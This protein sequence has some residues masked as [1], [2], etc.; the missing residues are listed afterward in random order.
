MKDL[1]LII[2]PRVPNHLL[3]KERKRFVLPTLFLG[4]AALLLVI[5][6]LLPYWKMTLYAPQ[7]PSG[8]KLVVY[9]NRVTGDVNE[10]D[11]LNHYIG[12]RS[13]T[14]AASLERTLSIIAVAVI[15]L[16]VIGAIYVH[17]PMALF[18]AIPA[19]AFPLLF[20]GDLWFWMWNFGMHLDPKAPLNHAVKPFVPPV[21]GEGMVGQFR[22][23]ASWQIGLWLAIVASVLIVIGLYYHRK[24]YKPLLEETLSQKKSEA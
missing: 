12:M 20:L 7:Y 1:D 3:K 15:A 17:S 4:G 24:A 10:I 5:S 9:V 2:G 18:F 14:E 16:L 22:T 23:V 8:L 13:L 11:T 21:V 6:I 19:F